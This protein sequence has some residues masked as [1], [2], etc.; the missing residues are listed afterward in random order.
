MS[1]VA[2]PLTSPDLALERRGR[3]LVLAG[4][5]LAVSLSALETTIVSTAMPAIVSSLGGMK[6]YGWI[7][8]TYLL[9]TTATMP[10]YG[11]LGDLY[12]RKPMLI[13][14]C[15]LFMLGSVLCACA[16]SITSLA[17]FRAVQG[18]G[19][20][21]IVPLAL[22]LVGDLYRG[23]KRASAQ[24]WF[25]MVWGVASVAGPVSGAWVTSHLG[26]RWIFV[27]SVPFGLA[28]VFAL[29]RWLPR[30]RPHEGPRVDLAGAALLLAGLGLVV[31]GAD[32]DARDLVDFARL[33]G[34]SA[35]LFVRAHIHA[36]AA[37]VGGAMLVVFLIW[38]ARHPSPILPLRLFRRP[39]IFWASVG[40]L[41]SGLI[42]FG[43]LTFVPLFVQGVRLGSTKDAGL[44]L[45]PMSVGWPLGSLIAGRT[46]ARVG[47]RAHV[48]VGVAL[49][50]IGTA[51][52]ATLPADTSR[53][54]LVSTMLLI[55]LGLG[56]SSLALLVNVQDDAPIEHRGVATA[57]QAFFRSIGGV[58][59]VGLL[60]SALNVGVVRHY[61]KVTRR[62][63][64]R[65]RED[66]KLRAKAAQM[67]QA[68]AAMAD[69]MVADTR[70]PIILLSDLVDA[71]KRDKL[72]RETKK[73][74]QDALRSGLAPV[75][76]ALLGASV[77]AIA[78]P[79]FASGRRRSRLARPA[80]PPPG[81][82]PEDST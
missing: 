76:W 22:A 44:V 24:G 18:L 54:A 37:S 78:V 40:A 15:L 47:P 55:G 25:S 71:R 1:G 27:L 59:G 72:Q 57:S 3:A 12:G 62:A 9:T 58:V 34:T 6:R 29:A 64:S 50:V 20:G 13:A 73:V 17:T 80:G 46:M 42:L 74:L 51:G 41:L 63:E 16:W 30:S 36:L 14:A 35:A 52:L 21:G 39:M 68:G 48:A 23:S 61:T 65:L 26:W 43:V 32:R 5:L 81:S 67:A 4:I 53:F 11:R 82:T 75:Y 7:V 33:G 8:V 28:A 45:L 19:S 10:I 79:V 70:N 31:L 60:A 2:A 69:P 66:P 49:L 56:F 77:L 38:E